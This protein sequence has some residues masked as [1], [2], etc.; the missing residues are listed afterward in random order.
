MIKKS[1]KRK[2]LAVLIAVVALFLVVSY[3][4]AG[5][6]HSTKEGGDWG[7]KETWVDGAVPGHEDN[8]VLEGKVVVSS[9]EFC[10]TLT[11]KIGSLLYI[12]TKGVLTCTVLISEEKDGE[13]GIIENKNIIKVGAYEVEREDKY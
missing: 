10:D 11:V 7:D 5:E 4:F 6:I 8:V 1:K 9:K 13:E 2:T 3:L 12:D